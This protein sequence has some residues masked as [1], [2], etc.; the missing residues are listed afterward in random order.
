MNDPSTVGI[1]TRCTTCGA[2]LHAY[3]LTGVCAEC[4]LIAR[5]ERPSGNRTAGAP[6]SRADAIANIQAVIGCRIISE[7]EADR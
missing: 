1:P 6:V 2:P 4:K 5:N 3:N 7:A